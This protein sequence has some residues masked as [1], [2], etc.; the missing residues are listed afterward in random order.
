MTRRKRIIVTWVVAGLTAAGGFLVWFGYQVLQVP[1]QA[2][3]VWW[4]AD[5]AIEH[6]E[7]HDGEWP[8]SW[9]ELRTTSELAYKGTISTNLYEGT[10]VA[11]FRPRDAIA[12][13]Q[14]LV[15]IDWKA[16]P[17]ELRKAEFLDDGKAP[18]RVIWL[19][20]GKNRHYVGREPNQMILGYLKRKAKQAEQG[21]PAP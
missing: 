16:N 17:S 1:K 5:L 8:R 15:E 4:T 21:A 20:N 2:Y 11:E 13:L 19:K 10:V 3:A 7:K 12:D 18:F 6:M 9:D 14:R